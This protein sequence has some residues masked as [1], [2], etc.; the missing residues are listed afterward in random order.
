MHLEARTFGIECAKNYE[1]WFQFFEVI[2][3]NINQTTIF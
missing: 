2:G 1:F 3:Y